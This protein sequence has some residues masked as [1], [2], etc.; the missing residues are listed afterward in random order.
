MLSWL[1]GCLTA[2]GSFL[3]RPVIK[4]DG[5]VVIFGE[6]EDSLLLTRQNTAALFFQP[7]R[8]RDAEA[9][10]FNRE[11]IVLRGGDF[12]G[13]AVVGL[14]EGRVTVDRSDVPFPTGV[15]RRSHS[16]SR[17]SLATGQGQPACRRIDCERV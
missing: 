12:M 7:L 3:S 16:G 10:R 14:E 11:G 2:S 17:R 4:M 5:K 1:A 13:G 8:S 15:V 6:Q 9:L